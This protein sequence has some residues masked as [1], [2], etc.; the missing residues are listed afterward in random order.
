MKV[1][2]DAS[3]RRVAVSLDDLRA[4]SRIQA[5]R[6]ANSKNESREARIR[7]LRS[8]AAS[9]AAPSPDPLPQPP[10][11]D[12]YTMPIVTSDVAAYFTAIDEQLR[13]GHLTCTLRRVA[14]KLPE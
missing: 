12:P 5:Q 13:A 1:D 9:E 8:Q 14:A 11:A 4:E 3:G 10:P 6:L 2:R 7:E